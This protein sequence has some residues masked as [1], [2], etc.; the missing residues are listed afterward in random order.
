MTD[1]LLFQLVA[2]PLLV[3]AAA[4]DVATRLIPDAVPVA[5]ALAGLAGRAMAGWPEA[6]TS[7]G[8]GLVLFALM[9]PL[10][11][12]GW[13]GGGDVKLISAMA[14]G[15]APQAAWL[16]IVATVFTGGALGLAYILGRHIAPRSRV[17]HGAS[18]PR[19]VLAVEAWRIRRR[20]PLPYAVAIAIGGL[21]VLFSPTG[22]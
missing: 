11:M 21:L 5:I 12:R 19:R 6:G 4:R 1:L 8:V 7:L 22:T 2:A 13:L 17:A 9:L 16:F 14:I 20:A 15:L 3:V 10:A 18:L